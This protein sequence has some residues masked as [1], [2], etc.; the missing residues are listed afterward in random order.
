MSRE[1][2][3]Q[4][5]FLVAF[6]VSGATLASAQVATPA[7]TPDGPED[8]VSP[9]GFVSCPALTGTD[10]T[11]V[12]I[13]WS[14]GWSPRESTLNLAV[15]DPEGSFSYWASSIVGEARIED[16]ESDA[17]GAMALAWAKGRSHWVQRFDSL[18]H[19]LGDR[20][21][22]KLNGRVGF[23]SDLQVIA[24]SRSA[25]S[26]TVALLDSSGHRRVATQVPDRQPPT[27]LQLAKSRSGAFSVVLVSSEI[28][29]AQFAKTGLP[30]SPPKLVARTRSTHTYYS[31]AAAM[32]PSDN[33]TVAFQALSKQV[34]LPRGDVIV[35]TFDPT[36]NVTWAYTLTNAAPLSNL[37]VN[38]D[39][40]LMLL[41]VDNKVSFGRM[42]QIGGA[43]S[44]S[45]NFGL[46]SPDSDLD[47]TGCPTAIATGPDWVTAWTGGNEHQP[48]AVLSRRFAG[49]AQ[50][51]A[52]SSLTTPG[53]GP[54][55]APPASVRRA[56]PPL[57]PSSA[58]R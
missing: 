16:L 43:G 13:A 9:I 7:P 11:H 50:R 41:F 33:L 28:V 20:L 10:S 25:G 15:G 40:Q 47:L 5:L 24:V 21:F 30:T 49:A 32:D 37:A 12:A 45:D 22:L 17:S 52:A 39:G 46:T 48:G 4:I 8:A 31:A 23:T 38:S 53:P 6:L 42:L 55:P 14:E 3:H 19:P 29:I 34:G 35:H 51:P 54:G 56:T 18:G 26:V 27:T 57:S 1:G 58:W 36:G 2:S 44:L